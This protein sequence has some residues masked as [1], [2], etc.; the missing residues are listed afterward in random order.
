MTDT[1]G[2]VFTPGGAGWIDRGV[3]LTNVAIAAGAKNVSNVEQLGLHHLGLMGATGSDSTIHR[4]LKLFDAV[5]V[6]KIARARAT[7]RARAWELIAERP[8]GFQWV[9]IAGK[10]LPG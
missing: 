8:V 9:T 6:K 2:A 5:M 7:A 3:V 1:L 4:T 10:R